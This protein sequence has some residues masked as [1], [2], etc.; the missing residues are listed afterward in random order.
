MKTKRK[1]VAMAVDFAHNS[2]SIDV[3]VQP[4]DYKQS[5]LVLRSA[6]RER[7]PGTCAVT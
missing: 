6:Y 7:R 2:G 5:G 1:A 3:Q 4:S